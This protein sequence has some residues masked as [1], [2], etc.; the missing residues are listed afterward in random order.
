MTYEEYDELTRIMLDR[1]WDHVL[2]TGEP[3]YSAED[4]AEWEAMDERLT[5]TFEVIAAGYEDPRMIHDKPMERLRVAQWHLKQGHQL[6]PGDLDA[7]AW[8]AAAVVDGKL[9]PR[10]R[11]RPERLVA[12]RE[13]RKRQLLAKHLRDQELS[14]EVV[15][16]MMG[17]GIEAR[18]VNELVAGAATLA[19][20]IPIGLDMDDELMAEILIE[21]KTQ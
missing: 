14:L 12:P 2:A 11:G 4:W 3:F 9:P 19:K 16:A 6:S 21:H 8:A 10:P 5:R 18:H 20:H 15:A 7:L 13:H 1:E 17:T